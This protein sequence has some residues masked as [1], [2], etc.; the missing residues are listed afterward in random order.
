MRKF[1]FLLIFVLTF[2]LTTAVQAGEITTCLLATRCREKDAGCSADSNPKSNPKYE[3]G[4]RAK[5][6]LDPSTTYPT[7]TD[8]EIYEYIMTDEG[9]IATKAD[10]SEPYMSFL[11]ER[12][13]FQFEG[14]FTSDGK[15]PFYSPTYGNTGSG[16]P[17][18]RTIQINENGNF[19]IDDAIETP[20]LEWQD[21]T[22][23][24]TDRVF[25]VHYNI[26]DQAEEPA[27]T[28]ERG[29]GGLQEADTNANVGGTAEY[30]Y[31][32]AV[33]SW[34]PAGKVFDS[35]SLEPVPGSLVKIYKRTNS[36]SIFTP[37]SSADTPYS[38]FENPYTTATDGKYSFYV[39]AY[40]DVP[41]YIYKLESAFLPTYL[42]PVLKEEEIHPNA[43][44]IYSQIYPLKSKV[45]P[46]GKNSWEIIEEKN[47]IE[48][49]DIPLKPADS[50]GRKYNLAVIS[51]KENR[52]PATGNY[53][54][55]IAYS[56]PFTKA[57]PYVILLG[58][59]NKTYQPSVY[60]DKDGKV[61]LKIINSYNKTISQVGVDG[62]KIDLTGALPVKQIPLTNIKTVSTSV[63][64]LVLEP[65]PS[66]IAGYAYDSNG[67]LIANA[68]V[69]ISLKYSTKTFCQTKADNYGFY[70]FSSNCIPNSPFVIKYT[71]PSGGQ[72][73]KISPEKFLAQNSQYLIENKVDLNK[74]V[75]NEKKSAN[76][77]PSL[78]DQKKLSSQGDITN[79]QQNNLIVI[80]IIL[81]ILILGV[82]AIIGVYIYRKNHQ[83]PT[84]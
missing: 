15:T 71:K 20:W 17:I 47:E 65:I 35:L 6:T 8:I 73:I 18:Y 5:L 63:T 61:R 57:K 14:L 34:D 53:L 54:V 13:E 24:G 77:T 67:Q 64:A 51:Y 41:H 62:E 21:S 56:H 28:E 69:T 49:R 44:L 76:I 10:P 81:L 22:R 70:R 37:V 2:Y 59:T 11:V 82:A 29:R 45:E 79:K 78:T 68:L 16:T 58:E 25:K 38:D 36:S 48:Y 12:Y 33:V 50:I 23:P 66:Y 72:L 83:P 75:S 40:D 52:D 1:I 43:Y 31:D 32:C 30:D 39:R 9:E 74:T 4:H 55:N 26:P 84:F 60:A 3:S 46:P 19:V 80:I 27:A 7:N 42:F